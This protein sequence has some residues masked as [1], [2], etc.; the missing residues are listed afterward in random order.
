MRRDFAPRVADRVSGD[1][2]V[3]ALCH[4][5]THADPNDFQP[6][7]ANYG[8]LPALDAAQSPRGKRDRYRA[9]GERA[10]GDMLKVMGDFA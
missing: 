8:I 1:D 2:D 10:Q 7:K 9:F 3:G 4:Y 5:V 6:M